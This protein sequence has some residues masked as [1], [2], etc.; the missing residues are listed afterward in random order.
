MVYLSLL[1]SMALGRG[2]PLGIVGFT[3]ML[4]SFSLGAASIPDDAIIVDSTP[5][6]GFGEAIAGLGDVN[7]DGFADFAVGAPRS[8]IPSGGQG[9]VRVYLGSASGIAETPTQVLRSSANLQG[10]GCRVAGGDWDRDGFGDAMILTTSPQGT[11]G[12]IVSISVSRGSPAG[13]QA[14]TEVFQRKSSSGPAGF[15]L[16]GDVNGD[17][18]PE[19]ALGLPYVGDDAGEV[20][21][22]HGGSVLRWN[23]PT[24]TLLPNQSRT[25]FG[26]FGQGQSDFNRDGYADLLVGSIHHRNPGV[27]SGRAQLFLGSPL[28]LLTNVVWTATY[29]LKA[30]PHIDDDHDHYFGGVIVVDDFNQDGLSDVV[31]TAAFAEQ[32]DPDEG[33][34]FC[35][36]GIERAP[37]LPQQFDWMVQANR[38]NAVLGLT[39]ERAGDVNGDGYPDLLLGAPD[40]G[41]RQ[42]REGLAAVFLGSPRGFSREPAWTLESQDTHCRLGNSGAGVGDLNG[43]GFDDLVISQVD[44]GVAPA[45]SGWIRVIYGSP[46]GP[47]Q[48]THVTLGKPVFQWLAEEWRRLTLTTQSAVGTIALALLAFIGFMGRRTWKKRTVI[49]VEKRERES[50]AA[51]RERIARNLHDEV[52]SRISRIHLIAEHVAKNP[53]GSL[54]TFSDA[55]THEANDLRSAMEQVASSLAPDARSSDQ[56]VQSLSRHAANFFTGTSVRCFQELPQDLPRFELPA[57]VCSELF[58]CVREALA[59]VLRHS[60]ASEVWLRVRSEEGRFVVNIADNGVGFSTDAVSRGNGLRNFQFRMNQVGG[61]ASIESAPAQGTRVV[62]SVP[63]P[64][65]RNGDARVAVLPEPHHQHP[66]T[67]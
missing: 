24:T 8:K 29:P 65:N 49:L 12:F 21:I 40:F 46:S 50:V 32:N 41:N 5:D 3:A 10:F 54:R 13:L 38:P 59:N 47:R 27:N 51:E 58:P 22:F 61:T 26:F 14:P 63:A 62:F 18:F 60:K 34:I 37:G 11:D 36:Y 28:G 52:G 4:A 15:G 2:T 7:G 56:L 16:I 6:T 45:K 44:P 33:L 43:D 9:E 42:L 53:D 35:F 23:A 25:A 66:A 67:T 19:L 17:G 64:K 30:R 48:S 39:A 55:I 20:L 1:P 31:I 57:E